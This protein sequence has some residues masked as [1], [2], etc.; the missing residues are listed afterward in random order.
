MV[1]VICSI[2]KRQE[3]RISFARFRQVLAMD[4]ATFEP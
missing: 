1:E 3:V 4:K 2:D